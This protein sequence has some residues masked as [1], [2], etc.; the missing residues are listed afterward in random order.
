[1][2][3]VAGDIQV[4][5][6]LK[7]KSVELKFPKSERY[8]SLEPPEVSPEFDS[9]RIQ[10]VVRIYREKMEPRVTESAIAMLRDKVPRAW[11]EKIIVRLGKSLWIPSTEEDFPSHDPYP[12][13]RII[14][15]ADLVRLEQEGGAQ[16]HVITSRLA[17]ILYEKTK[18]QLFSEL[19]TPVLYNEYA[20]GYLRI[21][22]TL[23]R[24]ERISRELL[25]YQQEFAKILCYSLATN[26]YFR[27]ETSTERRYEAPIIDMSAS[28]LLFAHTSNDLVR[29]LMVHND[30][31]LSFKLE[32]R[33]MKIGARIMRK[34]RDAE[35]VYF[36]VLFMKIE[37]ED[38]AALYQF[39][40]GKPFDPAADGRWEGGAPPPPLVVG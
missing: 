16:P 20:V 39:L 25:D 1:R 31:P 33:T 14:T 5:F 36:G 28:G 10:E 22:N 24:R 34:F 38:F 18:Q 7:G 21:W 26:G 35:N 15:K 9:D 8:K 23:P 13:G 11:E 6:S 4:S 27:A 40:Y 32:G 37:P 29:D 19:W 30:L 12:D 2:V 17:N 3:K